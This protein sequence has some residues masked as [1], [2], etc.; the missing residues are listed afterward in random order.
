MTDA[1]DAAVSVVTRDRSQLV[2][3]L[4]RMSTT[5]TG[6]VPKTE[7]HRQVRAAAPVAAVLP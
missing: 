2:L 7:C 5:V 1:A 6:R 3:D 4:S